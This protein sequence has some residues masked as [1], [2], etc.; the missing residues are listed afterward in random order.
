MLGSVNFFV[1]IMVLVLLWPYQ[2]LKDKRVLSITASTILVIIFAG[3]ITAKPIILYGE[4][5]KYVDKVIFEKQSRYQKIVI[6]EWKNQHWLF[7]NGNQQLSSL[8][9][10]MY[11][12]P[13]V[14]PAM[15]LAVHPQ[16][17][18]VLGGGD[19]C[20]VREILKYPEVKNIHLVDLD[21]EMTRL[22]KENP[23]LVEMNKNSLNQPLVTITNADG[24]TFMEQDALFYDVIIIDLPD[25]KTVELGRLY[26]Y[27]F[28]RLCY[29]HLRPDGIV[30]TQAGSPYYAGNAFICIE[31]TMQEAGFSVLPLHNQVITLGE[32]GWILGAK[33]I[34]QENI[35]AI[36]QNLQFEDVKTKWL[37]ND[38]MH[39]MTSFGKELFGRKKEEVRVNKI[40]DPVL[41]KYYLKGNWDIY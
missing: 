36:C 10:V 5:Q 13:L 23:I 27:E 4:Q 11:H 26:S 32:W 30:I 8:D 22:G 31:K 3:T 41:Y 6:T 18:L 33:S 24:Y 37:N 20:A 12:E 39:L 15:K 16:N 17:V 40:H 1:A 34:S 14:H 25:P 35:K 29:R 2:Q 28:Y 9:E 38:A 21:P 7:I 19:G